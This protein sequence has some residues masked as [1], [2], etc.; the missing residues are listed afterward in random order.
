MSSGI[1]VAINI[2]NCRSVFAAQKHS[3]QASKQLASNNMNKLQISICQGGMWMW[4]LHVFGLKQ[5][6][7]K[8]QQQAG[9][10]ATK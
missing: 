6:Q 4:C 8:Q 10:P 7:Q 1:I 9:M 2:F 5:L 3:Q